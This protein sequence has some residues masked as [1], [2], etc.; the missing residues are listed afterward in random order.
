MGPSI[1]SRASKDELCEKDINLPVNRFTSPPRFGQKECSMLKTNFKESC[2]STK[3]L[4]FSA[5]AVLWVLAALFTFASCGGNDPGGDLESPL[6]NT[7]WPIQAKKDGSSETLTV[8]ITDSKIVVT[9]SLGKV[10]SSQPYTYKD[11]LYFIEGSSSG[12]SITKEASGLTL[13]N[14]FSVP[15]YSGFTPDGDSTQI[16]NNKADELNDA[17]QG[18]PVTIAPTPGSASLLPGLLGTWI[19]SGEYNGA[20][21][22]DDYTITTTTVT[23]A[24][25]GVEETGSIEYVYNFDD[26]SGCIIVKYADGKYNGV[27]FG[28]LTATTADLGDAWDAEDPD[29]DSSVATLA[30]AIERFKPENAKNYGGGDAQYATG[31]AKDTDTHTLNSGL[32]GTWAASGESSYGPWTD[33][34]TITAGTGGQIGTITHDEG[35]TWTSATIE[36]VYN[37][38]ATSGCLI[39]KYTVDG[40]NKYN[41]VYFKDL[42][43]TQVLL[44]DAYTVADYTSSAVATLAE[45]KI[46]FKPEN[47]A[48]YG[49]GES[50]M[51]TPQQ[52]Q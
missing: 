34:Y 23:H 16:D 30:A 11:G 51:G 52:K 4:I 12:I 26:K 38:D 32:V 49:G 9:D 39:V 41:A 37:F 36:Y 21:W 50:Q 48:D 27:F 29:Y 13:G 40:T 15:D 3:R 19:D 7:S 28:N 43:T 24:E 22:T 47:A 2:I 46:R 10:V 8:A 45:A 44:G 35:Y 6:V 25:S 1:F 42:S 20:V 18:D 17:K 31:H 33:T 14:G 5:G